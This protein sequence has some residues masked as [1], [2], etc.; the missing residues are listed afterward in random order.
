MVV[1]FTA[2]LCAW[3]SNVR[4]VEGVHLHAFL[5][6]V[7]MVFFSTASLSKETVTV[8]GGVKYCCHVPQYFGR[9]IINNLC[10]REN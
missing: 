6:L 5:W 7:R 1:H 2:S 10:I 3:G 9:T 4:D 8:S